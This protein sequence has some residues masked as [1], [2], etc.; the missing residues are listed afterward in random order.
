M[1][2]VVS[3]SLI[4]GAE[5]VAHES[6][7]QESA[8]RV[9]RSAHRFEHYRELDGWRGISILTV[10]A[11]HLLPLGPRALELNLAAGI[12][13]MSIFFCLSGFL[14]T[15]F[16]VRRP[17]VSSFIVR[18]LCRILPLAYL[19]L[20]VVLLW[21]GVPMTGWLVN[22]GFI[23]NYK[24]E[25]LA[26]LNGHFWSL[27]VEMQ[28][29]LAITLAV[30]VLR[31]W[32]QWTIPTACLFVTGLRIWT[33]TYVSIA[34]HL[35]ADEIL[36]GGCLALLFNSSSS[37][38]SSWLFR[39]LA[40]P[41]AVSLLLAST[42]SYTG[43]FQYGRPYFAALAVGSVLYQ[44]EH[45]LSAILRGRS[46]RYVAEISYALYVIH[47]ITAAGCL[48]AGPIWQKYL[49]KRP[50]SLVLTFMLAHLSTFH[51]ESR[52]IALGKRWTRSSSVHAP[53]D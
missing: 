48:G 31:R 19:Y 46:L 24:T 6:K 32:W 15:S 33:H 37:Y 21:Y 12:F 30:C 22:F 9:P 36:V 14:I 42:S 2:I 7:T 34:T 16:L 13:G 35:R 29:Y 53:P 47:P 27:C 17:N 50:I 18:R 38:S 45:W 23:E 44:P 49:V 4:A 40:P 52:W 43:A 25:Y 11:C 41:F 26:T 5:H 1:I 8:K 3:E 28:F 10:L 51:W 39:K 20:V